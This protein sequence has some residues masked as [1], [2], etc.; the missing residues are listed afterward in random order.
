MKSRGGQQYERVWNNESR[1]YDYTHRVIM[2]NHL[3]RKLLRC[4]H[5][6]H[7]NGNKKD[8]RIENLEVLRVNVHTI[9]HNVKV[10][11]G[12]IKDDLS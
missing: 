5:V 10:L 2:E 7:I 3:G 8:N 9:R 11:L 4:E 12:R 1:Q 6:H